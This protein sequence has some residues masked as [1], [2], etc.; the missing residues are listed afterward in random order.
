MSVVLPEE[1]AALADAWATALNVLGPEEGI[2][3]ANN[4]GIPAYYLLK[5]PSGFDEKFTPSFKAYL[6]G[7][8]P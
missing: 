6:Q 5:T 7:S 1:Q 4:S 2:Q 8:T 3:V